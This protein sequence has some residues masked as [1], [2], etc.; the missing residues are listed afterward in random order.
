MSSKFLNQGIPQQNIDVIAHDIIAKN[1]VTGND[2]IANNNMVVTN[3]FRCYQ[4]SIFDRNLNIGSL[5]ISNGNIDMGDDNNIKTSDSSTGTM[6]ALSASEKLSFHG[7]TPGT[8]HSSTGE[9]NGVSGGS[10]ATIHPDTTFSGNVGN[11]AYTI[12]DVIKC[13]KN[14]GL[15]A[16]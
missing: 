3:N 15:L 11:S 9:T 14:K 13:L 16:E 4:D 12:S 2:L 8:Q 7:V 1:D 5:T 6:I 10:G